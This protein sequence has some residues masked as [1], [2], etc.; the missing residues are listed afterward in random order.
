M[1][2]REGRYVSGFTPATYKPPAAPPT[3][4]ARDS[5]VFYRAPKADSVRPYTPFLSVTGTLKNG[6]SVRFV[7]HSG[8]PL[9]MAEILVPIEDDGS[10]IAAERVLASLLPVD[11]GDGPS[12]ED[13]LDELG[14]TIESYAWNGFI[15]IEIRATHSRLAP[16]LS[17]VGR[18]LS[19]ARFKKEDFERVR[20]KEGE[21]WASA[22]PKGYKLPDIAIGLSAPRSEYRYVRNERRENA[23]SALTLAELERFWRRQNVPSRMAVHITGPFDSASALE[24][25]EAA[26]PKAK[27]PKSS[28]ASSGRVRF[29]PGVFVVEADN[30]D[31]VEGVILWPV[32]SWASQKHQAAAVM[33]WLFNLDVPNGLG[34]RMKENGAKEPWWQTNT[35]LTRYG[36]FLRYSFQTPFDQVAPLFKSLRQ[37]M[38]NMSDGHIPEMYSDRA[39][40]SEVE[41]LIGRTLTKERLLR[42]LY[43]ANMHRLD[44]VSALETPSALRRVGVPDVVELARTLRWETAIIALSGPTDPL[45]RLAKD[46]ELGPV[47]VGWGDEPVPSTAAKERKP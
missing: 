6:A 4:A 20:K 12:L 40:N 11:T 27:A 25:A 24:M 9:A 30:K 42:Q 23:V 37:H 21:S 29:R 35:F 36:D 44:A 3:L 18:A 17:A 2:P 16:A 31:Y 39:R 43:F 26:L 15:D 46:L 13:E 34:A 32:P 14:A 8:M 5:A 28:T 47:A 41:F 10:G 38:A 22:K 45:A 33:T 7:A 1:A 19:A